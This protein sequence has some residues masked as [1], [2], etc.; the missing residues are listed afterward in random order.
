ME[1]VTL[2]GLGMRWSEMIRPVGV[3]NRVGV[4]VD[5][6]EQPTR[7]RVVYMLYNVVFSSS[8][9]FFLSVRRCG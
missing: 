6:A 3:M 5:C 9:L 4:G 1:F 8:F 2:F 7:R